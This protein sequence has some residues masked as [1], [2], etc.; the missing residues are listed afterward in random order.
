MGRTPKRAESRRTAYPGIDTS[1]GA[2]NRIGDK[3]KNVYSELID[4]VGRLWQMRDLD[5]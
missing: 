5:R 4:V 1:R 2:R 3:F